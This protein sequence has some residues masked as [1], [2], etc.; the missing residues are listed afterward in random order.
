MINTDKKKK[1]TH[2]AKIKNKPVF[3]EDFSAF[4]PVTGEKVAAGDLSLA[5][6]EAVS[7]AKKSRRDPHNK[8]ETIKDAATGGSLSY[9]VGRTLGLKDSKRIKALTSGRKNG[10]L[11]LAAAG[12][13]GAMSA[14]K[15]KSEY[16]RQQASRELLSG[17]KTGRSTA[18]K[19]YLEKKYSLQG[20]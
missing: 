19:D 18:Y 5:K 3:K 20:K 16:N 7:E 2:L 9:L 10:I 12:V 11:G 6:M 17:K 15:Q 8:E 1:K 13:A 4:D 14:K